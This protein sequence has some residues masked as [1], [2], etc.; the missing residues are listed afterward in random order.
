MMNGIIDER[1]GAIP[2]HCDITSPLWHHHCTQ[3][4]CWLLS[5]SVSPSADAAAAAGV[6]V[7]NGVKDVAPTLSL[8]AANRLLLLLTVQYRP[9]AAASTRGPV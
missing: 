5:P 8:M 1:D 9:L 7:K 3:P 2:N 6:G 4:T